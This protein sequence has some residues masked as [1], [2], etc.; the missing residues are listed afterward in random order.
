[1]LDLATGENRIIDRTEDAT[2]E[3]VSFAESEDWDFTAS[4]GTVIRGFFLYP[5]NFDP[6][7]KYPLIVNYYGG[8]NP[9][10]KSFGG[11]YPLDIW[12]GEGYV[13]YVPQ[14]SG[15]TG[16]GQAPA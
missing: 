4:G 7:K 5:R 12:A 16:F 15:A 9:I 3:N 8:T 14:P 13:V 11:R 1:M 2:Y 6:G 10:E